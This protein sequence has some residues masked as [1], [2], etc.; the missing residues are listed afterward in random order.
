MKLK[1]PAE[2]QER[3]DGVLG[4]I[5]GSLYT[6]PEITDQVYAMSRAVE[7]KMGLP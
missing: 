2:L 3:A 7:I 4:A 1:I 5:F 6:I